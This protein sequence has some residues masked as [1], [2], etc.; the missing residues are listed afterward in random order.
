M[1]EYPTTIK[2][3]MAVTILASHLASCIRM[4][5]SVVGEQRQASTRY[6]RARA[7][8]QRLTGDDRAA[9]VAA[10]KGDD[11]LEARALSDIQAFAD[12]MRHLPLLHADDAD[13][14]QQAIEH[15]R[16]VLDVLEGRMGPRRAQQYRFDAE[17][18]ERCLQTVEGQ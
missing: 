5:A 3:G 2:P 6:E 1:E 16:R 13:E 7:I 11:Q 10:S 15:Y 17:L 4:A 9:D 12:A 14:R 8:S 18:C